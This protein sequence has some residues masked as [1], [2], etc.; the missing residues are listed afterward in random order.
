MLQT[1]YEYISGHTRQEYVSTIDCSHIHA[2]NA[3]TRTKNSI[4]C[5]GEAN[6]CYKGFTTS[7]LESRNCNHNDLL[8]ASCMY[9]L[10]SSSESCPSPTRP[11]INV[12]AYASH[13]G[14]KGHSPDS[15]RFK[16]D[17]EHLHR[18]KYIMRMPKIS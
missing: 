11:F 1:T 5:I 12:L 8:E 17:C 9:A 2:Q 4:P 3:P 18:G 10:A 16:S 6:Y 15:K 7:E 14:R 13:G